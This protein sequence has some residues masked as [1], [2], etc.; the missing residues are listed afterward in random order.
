MNLHCFTIENTSLSKPVLASERDA[1]LSWNAWL[2]VLRFSCDVVFFS[3]V[4]VNLPK[5][6]EEYAFEH[7]NRSARFA[8]CARSLAALAAGMLF[9]LWRRVVS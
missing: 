2:H 4:S 8:R 6:P 1:R 9:F 5:N 7:L 3:A